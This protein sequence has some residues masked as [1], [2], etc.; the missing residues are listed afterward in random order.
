MC[1]SLSGL[2]WL[3]ATCAWG[4]FNPIFEDGLAVED[5]QMSHLQLLYIDASAFCEA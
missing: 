1:P 5:F 4:Q 2:L 3:S